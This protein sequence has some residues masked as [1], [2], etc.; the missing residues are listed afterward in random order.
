MQVVALL[1]CAG[2]LPLVLGCAPIEDDHRVHRDDGEW[3]FVMIECTRWSR[4][5]AT[6]SCEDGAWE[7]KGSI[8]E[9]EGC[10]A[11][12]RDLDSAKAP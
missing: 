9:P 11:I 6:W 10:G 5:N 12:V 1:L 2:T 3:S 8:L 7:C 4:F